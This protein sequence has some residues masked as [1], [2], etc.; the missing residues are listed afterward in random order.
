MILIIPY[1]LKNL[2][3]FLHFLLIL[4]KTDQLLQELVNF[5][6]LFQNSLFFLLKLM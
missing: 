4:Q 5:P 6:I 3:Y 2:N 1:Q